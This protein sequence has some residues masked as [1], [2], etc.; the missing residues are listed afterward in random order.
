M[1]GGHVFSIENVMSNSGPLTKEQVIE[2]FPD[3]LDKGL[4]LLEG[5]Y[6]IRLND[7]AK[8][9][10]HAPQRGQVALPSKIKDTLAELHSAGVIEPV[11]RPMPW[12]SSMLAVPKKNGKIRI[13]P[14]PK[15]LNKAILRENYPIPTI[16]TRLHGASVLRP[17]CKEWLL[18]RQIGRGVITSDYLSHTLW[19][20]W[21]V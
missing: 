5:E 18:V 11:S 20:L 4:G 13:C 8:P 17:R 12:I 10:Q 16:A 3:V 9:I 7:S 15:D 21:L 2:M 6:R 14:D 1:S 19:P